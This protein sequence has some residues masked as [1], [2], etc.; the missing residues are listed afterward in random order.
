M[1]RPASLL[2]GLF[3]ISLSACEF[4]HD[5]LY[6]EP[7]TSALLVLTPDTGTTVIFQY[8]DRD[9]ED[10]RPPIVSSG[11][12]QPNTMY[13]AE[14]LLN[15]MGKHIIDTTSIARNPENY[16]V[17]FF[18][19]N[20]L[21]LTS[22]YSDYDA[23]GFPIGLHSNIKTLDSSDGSLTIIIKRNPNKSSEGVSDGDITN[24]GGKT[25]FEVAFD[26]NISS[27]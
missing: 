16:Q 27:G 23:N 21:E 7:I 13:Q 17:F 4:S 26:V 20:G 3:A 1:F 2:F 14:L 18:P 10:G 22:K 5:E 25:S 9:G 24:A 12:L 15:T 8:L 6:E 11:S 19:Q